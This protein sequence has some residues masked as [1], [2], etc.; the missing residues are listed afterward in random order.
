MALDPQDGLQEM[1]DLWSAPTSD[2]LHRILVLHPPVRE[3]A[4]AFEPYFLLSKHHEA[5]PEQTL[6]TAVLLLTDARWRKGASHLMRQ[7]A[8]GGLLDEEQLDLLSRTFLVADDAVYWTVPADWFDAKGI[9]ITLD[10]APDEEDVE[11]E[12]DEDDDGPVVAR[13]VLAPPL[14][15]WAASRELAQEPATW[16]ALLA[17]ARELNAR[18]GAAIMA[19][20]LD[21]ADVLGADARALLIKHAT[22]WPHHNVRLLAFE[23][24]AERDGA[25]TAHALAHDDPNAKIRAWAATLARR[26]RAPDGDDVADP[27][28]PWQDKAEPPTLF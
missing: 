13:R 8:D 9:E 2:A 19:G 18:H 7:I 14:R 11:E 5:E 27:G 12:D 22:S 23:L 16:A 1:T 25:A 6:A 4:D 21:Q 26:S 17:R 3:M 28:Q 24:I 10:V 20:M 15:R